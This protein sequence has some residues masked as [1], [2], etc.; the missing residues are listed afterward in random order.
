MSERS[1]W[2]L[3]RVG[4]RS[5]AHVKVPLCTVM[6]QPGK[7]KMHRVGVLGGLGGGWAKKG[8]PWSKDRGRG[9]RSL[10]EG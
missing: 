10:G 3:C 6:A 7:T 2:Y 4:G 8:N 5:W 1:W 9:M